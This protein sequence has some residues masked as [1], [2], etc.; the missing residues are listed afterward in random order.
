MVTV[1]VPRPDGD[2]I[3]LMQRALADFDSEFRVLADLPTVAVAVDLP[4]YAPVVRAEVLVIPG[5]QGLVEAKLATRLAAAL[6]RAGHPLPPGT[7][8]SLCLRYPGAGGA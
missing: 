7:E 8:V 2:L 5:R 4:S 3:P 1:P 6:E